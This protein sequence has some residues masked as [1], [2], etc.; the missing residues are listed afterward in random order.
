[1]FTGVCLSTGGGR[2]GGGG[3]TPPQS[4]TMGY[5]QLAGGTHPTG[6]HSC[7]CYKLREGNAYRPPKMW[8]GKVFTGVCLFTGGGVGYHWESRE[9]GYTS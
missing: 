2:F 1:M 9:V 7:W 6:M 8:E 4:D 3:Q 5:G